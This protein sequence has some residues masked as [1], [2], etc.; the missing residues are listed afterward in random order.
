[1]PP[2]KRPGDDP[3]GIAHAEYSSFGIC[4]HPQALECLGPDPLNP[5]A[6][7]GMSCAGGLFSDRPWRV[8][9]FSDTSG[10]RA[11]K[12]SVQLIII[13]ILQA[14]AFSRKKAQEAKTVLIRSFL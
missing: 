10:S 9:T 1:M 11:P 4:L 2:S 3:R 8:G 6:N 14:K 5:L 7:E 13:E 12:S